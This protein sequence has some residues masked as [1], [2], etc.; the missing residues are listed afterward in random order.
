MMAAMAFGAIETAAMHF[1]PIW[2]SRSG[3]EE[4]QALRLIM[5]GAIGV[6]ALQFPIGWL[7]DKMDRYTLLKFCALGTLIAPIA[8]WLVIGQ[9]VTALYVI[10]FI[11]VGL[12]EGLYILALVLVGQKFSHKEMTA[13]SAAIVLMYGLG[14]MLSPLIIGPL[15][16]IFNPNGAM[17]GLAVFA[18]AYLAFTMMYR[19]NKSG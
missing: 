14:S 3:L 13:A 9:S 18:L 12:G 5:V 4:T 7:G 19:S 8:M 2:A 15:M 17:F 16:D 1:S 6:I 11:Y 10:F